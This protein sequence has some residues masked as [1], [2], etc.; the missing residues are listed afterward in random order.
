VF[1][2]A[3][4]PQA[5]DEVEVWHV[6]SH[7]RMDL[8]SAENEKQKFSVQFAVLDAPEMEATVAP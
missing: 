2:D 4:P 8:A 5:G 6:K 1:A 3:G 7:E